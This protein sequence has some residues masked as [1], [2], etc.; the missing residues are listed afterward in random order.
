MGDLKTR[1]YWLMGLRVVVVTLL[2]GFSIAFQIAKGERVLAFYA[3][4]GA[5]YA[6]TIFSA[7]ISRYI[8]SSMALT[9]FAYVQIGIDLILETLLIAM[10]GATESPF[11][12]LYVITVVLATLI[13]R[14]RIALATGAMAVLLFG[15]VTNI[16][17]FGLFEL[18]GLIPASR[19]SV[20]ETFQTFGVHG[21]AFVVVGLLSGALAD[22]L[23]RTDE[24]LLEK[25]RGFH[26]LQAFHENIVQS[27]SSGVFTTDE[28][29]RITSFN[30]AAQDITGYSVDRVAGYPWRDVFHWRDDQRDPEDHEDPARHPQRFEIEDVRAD[31]TRL[32]L[33]L[34][35]SPLTEGGQRTGLVGVFKDLTQIRAMEEEMR[36]REW[37]ATLGEMSAGM[38]HE[39]R[40]PLG[41][42]V[43]AMQMLQKDQALEGTNR[44]LMDIAIREA[45]RLDAIIKEFLQYARHPALN[46]K[47]CDLQVVLQETLDLIQHEARAHGGITIETHFDPETMMTHVDPDQ[48]KQVF[49]NL[50]ANAFQAMPSGGSLTISTTRRRVGLSGRGT[51]VIEVAFQDTGEGINKEH[52]DR[53][54]LP[55]YTTKEHGSGLGLAAIDRIVDLHGGWIRVES[56]EGKGTLFAVCLPRHA[57]SQSRPAHEGR[58]P[59]KNS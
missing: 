46:M 41:A 9:W 43:G 15:F 42:M 14:R 56:Q 28:A 23:R 47:E 37:L 13:P 20:P 31:G 50:A 2:L 11:S 26:R 59:W 27:I 8:T 33:G 38:A 53:I 17:V 58:G 5:T 22:Q 12:S 24:S 29:G 34:T 49:W 1:L 55:F 30:R 32:V 19:V 4:I 39:I 3:L 48:I 18:A 36:R 54:F 52:L 10:T 25:E 6:V 51:D 7:V 35:L 57:G 45:I 40:N 16:Q 44:H 21:L